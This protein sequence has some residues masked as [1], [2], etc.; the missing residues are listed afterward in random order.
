MIPSRKHQQA[1]WVN[2]GSVL[3]V[4]A[5]TRDLG[6]CPEATIPARNDEISVHGYLIVVD[7]SFYPRYLLRV[8]DAPRRRG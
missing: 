8:N 6:V 3:R 7:P 1:R 5:S 2:G 4:D